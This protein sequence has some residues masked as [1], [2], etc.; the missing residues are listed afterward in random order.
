MNPLSW[1]TLY[2]MTHSLR[3]P[4][5][6]LSSCHLS[7]RRW[8]PLLLSVALDAAGYLRMELN[9]GFPLLLCLMSAQ[10]SAQPRNLAGK[11]SHFQL[12]QPTTVAAQTLLTTPP[13]FPPLL[14]ILAT[15][16]F[17]FFQPHSLK[18]KTKTKAQSLPT[19]LKITSS[20]G[21]LSSP[22]CLIWV[23][24]S[25]SLYLRNSVFLQPSGH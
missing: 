25:L 21:S 2:D 8:K 22:V 9:I 1:K 23:P 4:H 5:T 17:F 12:A 7:F 10:C 13:S 18:S 6:S 20:S 24:V 3:S 19:V 14:K 16:S 11:G 15:P